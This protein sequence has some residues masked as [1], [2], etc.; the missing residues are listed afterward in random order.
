MVVDVDAQPLTSAL[1][2]FFTRLVV[3]L[4]GPGIEDMPRQRESQRIRDGNFEARVSFRSRM[5]PQELRTSILHALQAQGHLRNVTRVYMYIDIRQFY[6][7]FQENTA[8]GFTRV[9]H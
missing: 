7:N 2:L 6:L 3:L 5:M 1:D 8:S 9:I 4:S